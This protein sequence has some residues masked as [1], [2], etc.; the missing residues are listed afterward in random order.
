MSDRI[1]GKPTHK[2]NRKLTYQQV[3]LIDEYLV[4]GNK[5]EAGR[6]AGYKNDSCTYMAFQDKL[7]KEE[8]SK[9]MEQI[10][11]EAHYDGVMNAHEIMKMY[12]QIAKGEVLDQFGL[13]ASLKDRISALNELAKRQIDLQMKLDAAK[14]DNKLTIKIE[15]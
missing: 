6:R 12:S 8:L 9:R 3:R 5:L 13:E 1:A 4:T 7:V 11:E 2:S 15:R 14:Q 10:H